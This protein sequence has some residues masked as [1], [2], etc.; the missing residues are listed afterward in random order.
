[1]LGIYLFIEILFIKGL[2]YL[3]N[4]SN[5]NEKLEPQFHGILKP[6]NILLDN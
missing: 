4:P 2:N 1:M 3:H 6:A 5:P